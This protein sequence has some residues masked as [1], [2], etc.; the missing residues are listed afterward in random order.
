MSD[1]NITTPVFICLHL[2]SVSLPVILLSPF[3]H[4]I[5]S[6]NRYVQRAVSLHDRFSNTS[7]ELIIFSLKPFPLLS[8]PS[9]S[10]WKALVLLSVLKRVSRCCP[11]RLS[12]PLPSPGALHGV[13][14]RPPPG[15]ACDCH[16]PSRHHFP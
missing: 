6:M 14:L 16:W 7:N 8:F 3:Y 12:L 15:W 1:I 9:Q 13:S 10:G 2:P 5:S 11:A 4:L